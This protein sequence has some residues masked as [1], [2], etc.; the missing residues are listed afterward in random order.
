MWI[1]GGVHAVEY[2][3]AL[4]RAVS[5]RTTSGGRNRGRM[6]NAF[7]F[8]HEAT[9]PSVVGTSFSIAANLRLNFFDQDPPGHAALS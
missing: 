5:R 4:G 7:G 8:G 6:R 2:D 9:Y 1:I 3:L